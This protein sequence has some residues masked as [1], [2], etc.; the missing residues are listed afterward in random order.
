MTNYTSGQ[1]DGNLKRSLRSYLEDKVLDIKRIAEAPLF[2][3]MWNDRNDDSIHLGSSAQ[4]WENVC[5]WLVSGEDFKTLNYA[6]LGVAMGI[7]LAKKTV[8]HEER[9]KELERKVESLET[10][11]RRLRYGN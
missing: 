3:F 1:R 9:I 4:Y 2:T 11:N 8:N 7:S 6:T 10:E 5:P